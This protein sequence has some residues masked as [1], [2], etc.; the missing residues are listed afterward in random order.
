VNFFYKVVVEETLGLLHQ[1]DVQS[2]LDIPIASCD[3]GP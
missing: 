3:S 1:I 2:D